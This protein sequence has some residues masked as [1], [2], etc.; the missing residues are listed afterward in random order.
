MKVFVYSEKGKMKKRCEDSAVVAGEIIS[1]AYFECEVDNT[2]CIVALADGV[3]GNA[4]GDCASKYVLSELK[5]ISMSDISCV[6]LKNCIVEMNEKLLQY[7]FNTTDKKNMAT[8]MTGLMFAENKEFVFHI[9]NTRLYMLQRS[10]LKQITQ[11]QT[12]YQWFVNQ[13]Q[14]ESA[15]SCNRN[16]IT[17][18]MGGGDKKFINGLQ[19]KEYTNL[20]Q[21]GRILMTTDGIHEYVSIDELEEFMVGDVSENKIRKLTEKANA[22]GSEDDKTIIVID[23]M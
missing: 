13:G 17:Y 12:I 15:Q 9:G 16:E 22:K 11:D 5:N 14:I 8:T 20:K 2:S 21:C 10:Y 4:G 18:C 23:K 3:G 7:G 6:D 19:V 1:D